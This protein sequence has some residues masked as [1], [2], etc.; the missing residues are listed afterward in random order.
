MRQIQYKKF[1]WETHA[2]NWRRSIPNVSQFELTFKCALHCRHCYTDCYNKPGLTGRELNTP[3]VKSVIDKL[4]SLGVIWLCFT[5]G[6]PLERKDFLEIYAY[7]KEKGFIVTIFTNGYSMTKKTADYLAK[8]PP[9]AV[10]I[11]V[12]AATEKTYKAITGIADSFKKTASGLDLILKRKIPL[13]VK[14]MALSLNYQELPKIKKFLAVRNIEF[15]PSAI[16]HARL[17]GEKTPC[18][19]RLSPQQIA[20]L[21]KIMSGDH[22]QREKSSLPDK[23]TSK[24][25][26]K[27]TGQRRKRIFPCA[28]GSSDGIHIDPSGK[29]FACCCLRKPSIDFLRGS[30]AKIKKTLL[31]DF[32]KLQSLEFKTDSQC[33]WCALADICWG[34][35]G[36]KFLE[37][38]S[39]E[40]PVEYFCSVAEAISQSQP[41]SVG[42]KG[43]KYNEEVKCG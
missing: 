36:K 39:L 40:A 22:N 32:S 1:S 20:N 5:G 18:A 6:D 17:N 34:C 42:K 8:N 16:V 12:N 31:E 37:S 43:R 28:V 27:R 25:I 24:L 35:P 21:D 30:Q 14:T 38:K 10:E 13:K 9:F 33:A 4:Y 2:K 23:N 3:Q 41:S 15:T 29:M 7:A 26:N 11:T 19:I